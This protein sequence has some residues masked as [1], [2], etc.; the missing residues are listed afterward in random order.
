MQE[1]VRPTLQTTKQHRRHA[2][3]AGNRST[4]EPLHRSSKQEKWRETENHRGIHLRAVAT[5]T[6]ARGGE[7][8]VRIT[9]GSKVTDRAGDRMGDGPLLGSHDGGSSRC[10]CCA[11]FEAKGAKKSGRALTSS[12]NRCFDQR[13]QL[14]VSTDGQLEMPGSDAL[15]FEILRRITRQFEYLRPGRMSVLSRRRRITHLSRQVLQNRGRVHG[16]RGSDS[17]MARGPVLQVA[18][19]TSDRELRRAD[20]RTADEGALT[21]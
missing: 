8:R 11:E 6:Q 5:E 18:V 20:V 3:T 7:F 2:E 17:T 1:L 21:H 13:I 9:I 12:C 10:E 4:A 16:S 19:D 14:F 15:H